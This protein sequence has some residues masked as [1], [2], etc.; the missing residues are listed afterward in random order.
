VPP[1]LHGSAQD[2]RAPQRGSA[3]LVASEREV[4]AS[5]SVSLSE[6]SGNCPRSIEPPHVP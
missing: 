3:P 6:V 5:S 1:C 2:L 4:A